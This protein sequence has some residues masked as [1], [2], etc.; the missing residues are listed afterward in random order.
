L[1]SL[2]DDEAIWGEIAGRMAACFRNGD[3]LATG[4]LSLIPDETAHHS[5]R[6][7]E[8]CRRALPEVE[9]AISR[10]PTDWPLW[11][12]W[13]GMTDVLGGRPLRP[14]LD[15][16]TPLPTTTKEEWPPHTVRIAWVQEARDRRNWA[17]IRD[18]LL[19]R[20]ENSQLQQALRGNAAYVLKINGREQ[21][22]SESGSEWRETL[23]PLVEALLHLGE[24]GRADEIVRGYFTQ[25]PWEALPKHAQQVALRC[26]QPGLSAQW[27]ALAAPVK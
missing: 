6:M 5:Q 10:K 14:L 24:T 8:T 2:E 7:R 22:R 4:A 1:L 21:E 18:L 26:A 9:S 19:P 3:W 12:L 23:E 15:S 27:G 17:E 13:L 16:L 11:Q 25:H 20:W